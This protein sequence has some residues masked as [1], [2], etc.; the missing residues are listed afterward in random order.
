M[1]K[2]LIETELRPLYFKIKRIPSP[3]YKKGSLKKYSLTQI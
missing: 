3:L 2:I 1:T